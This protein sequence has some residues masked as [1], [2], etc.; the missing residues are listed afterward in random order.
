VQL[1]KACYFSIEKVLRNSHSR[2]KRLVE[3]VPTFYWMGSGA[4]FREG[5]SSKNGGKVLKLEPVC[6]AACSQKFP[7]SF[8]RCN[9]NTI[10]HL[11]TPL[12][13]RVF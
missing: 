2:Q 1:R 4:S 10:S 3:L 6:F 13:V 12:Y 11:M 9:F 7:C 8:L 5:K